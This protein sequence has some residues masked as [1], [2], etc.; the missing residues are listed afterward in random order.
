[1]V[2][3]K[4]IMAI[5][6]FALLVCAC[7]EVPIS[8]EYT[9]AL[10]ETRTQSPVPTQIPSKTAAPSATITIE[11]SRTAT[12][13]ATVSP[14]GVTEERIIGGSIIEIEAEDGLSL[15]GTFYAPDGQSSPAPG[16]I[17]LHMLWSDRS[18]WENFA[19]QLHEAGYAVLA[20]DF[21]G[22]GETGGDVDWDKAVAD[23][24]STWDYL[25]E[26]QAVDNERRA[27]VG[28]SIGA[29]VALSAAAL[30]P[31]VR[32]VILLSPGGDYAGV[33]TH[34]PMI[35][36]GERSVLIAASEQ[37]SY[38][39]D[40]SLRLEGLAAGK[41]ELIMYPGSGHGTIMLEREPDLPD[42]IISWLDDYLR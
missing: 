5:G 37:D 20:M 42:L 38:A 41:A 29:N 3:Y 34:D 18:T 7:Q 19:M 24:Q 2:S 33:K 4:W 6:V 11:L 23:V 14:S 36:Y 28:A 30:E 27:I 13:E 32:T 31:T 15:V 22:H 8:T 9:P 10:T 40:S 1:M 12:Q 25:E 17:L 26:I 39:A 21:R 35:A 16:V